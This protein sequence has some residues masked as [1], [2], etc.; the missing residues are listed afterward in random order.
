[1][2]VSDN[3]WEIFITILSTKLGVSVKGWEISITILSTK[4]TNEALST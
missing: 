3:S 2:G 4:P 1:M